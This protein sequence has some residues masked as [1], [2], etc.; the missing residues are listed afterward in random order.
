MSSADPREIIVLLANDA[1]EATSQKHADAA[2]LLFDAALSLL[3]TRHKGEAA[4]KELAGMFS[5]YVVEQVDAAI[6]A[7]SGA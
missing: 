3:V 2:V 4:R 7:G 5:Q 1:L 6:Q